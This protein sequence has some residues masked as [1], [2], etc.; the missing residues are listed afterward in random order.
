MQGKKCSASGMSGLQSL[1]K[2]ELQWGARKQTSLFKEIHPVVLRRDSM[3]K[4]QCRKPSGPVF[5]QQRTSEI[6]HHQSQQGTGA[7]AEAD[8]APTKR[9]RTI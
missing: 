1:S 3:S 5:S 8:T 9:T 6:S 4:L 2:Q 7:S